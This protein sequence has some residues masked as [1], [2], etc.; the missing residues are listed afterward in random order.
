MR[1]I[2]IAVLKTL[3]LFGM[4]TPC[5][6]EP[7]SSTF[8]QKAQ[9]PNQKA[10]ANELDLI[11]N[12]SLF[13]T[14]ILVALTQLPQE[15][16]S[17]AL[18]QVSGEEYTAAVL[19]TQNL[20]HQ[21]IRRLYDPL[22][23]LVNTN[24]ACD[25][26]ATRSRVGWSIWG[27]VSGGGAQLLGDVN[28]SGLNLNGYEATLGMQTTVDEFTCGLAGSYANSRVRYNV[29]G[30]EN[31]N[32]YFGGFYAL[33]RPK[34]FYILADFTYGYN[35]GRMCRSIDIDTDYLEAKSTPQIIQFAFYGELGIDICYYDLAIQPYLGVEVDRIWRKKVNE[36]NA[37][38]F[39]LTVNELK[40]TYSSGNI[41]LHLAQSFC[42][43]TFGCDIAWIYRFTEYE[44]SIT[45]QFATFGTF[46]D[47]MGVPLDRNSVEGT[48]YISKQ[49]GNGWSLY[50]EIAAQ[51]WNRFLSYDAQVGIQTRW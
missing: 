10:V 2:Q 15:Q 51:V 13:L 33:Y 25:P 7:F 46:F 4:L 28:C 32:S 24:C 20:N 49:I 3:M 43:Y 29:G 17:T 19:L 21:F 47:I 30:K 35:K 41:G 23:N 18:C 31:I 48:L 9:T 36:S 50:G 22:R 6:A 8:S 38:D 12:P 16:F 45:N 34:H 26:C 40:K 37:L 5:Q 39:N 27:D 44:N 42:D 1:K 14:D 11:Q